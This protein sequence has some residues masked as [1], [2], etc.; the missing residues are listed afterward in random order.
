MCSRV[1]CSLGSLVLRQFRYFRDTHVFHGCSSK[2]IFFFFPALAPLVCLLCI[3]GSAQASGNLGLSLVVGCYLGDFSFLWDQWYLK[4]QGM[5]DVCSRYRV[6]VLY[7]IPTPLEADNQG[8]YFYTLP[9]C[10]SS[11]RIFFTLG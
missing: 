2:L 8:V 5:D 6:R 3:P 4:L 9:N 10:K 11:L 7:K 1:Q